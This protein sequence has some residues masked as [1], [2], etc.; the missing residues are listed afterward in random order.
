MDI[1]GF[2]VFLAGMLRLDAEG[3]GAEVVTL[4]LEQVGGKVL[5]AVSVVETQGSAESRSGDTP[6]G[7]LAYNVSPAF[8]GVVDRLGE[9][10]V[11]QQILEIWVVAVGVGDVLQE[12]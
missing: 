12:D 8:L 2:G 9:E 5:G 7:S 10:R 11:E 4:S 3:V 6:K 1:L